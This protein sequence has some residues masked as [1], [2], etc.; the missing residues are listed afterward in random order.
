MGGFAVFGMS[1]S[2]AKQRAERKV[3]AYD[4]EKKRPL[5]IA[6]YK[7]AIEAMANEV[8]ESKARTQISPEFDAPQF[9]EEWM[10]LAHGQIKGAQIMQK[11]SLIDPK[12]L[13]PSFKWEPLG[14]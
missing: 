6:E 12:T 14:A 11:K 13:K 5:S 3:D 8:F 4:A 7:D 1:R 2:V 10:T 9:C